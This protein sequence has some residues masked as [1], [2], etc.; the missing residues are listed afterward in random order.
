MNVCRV[1]LPGETDNAIKAVMFDVLYEFFDVSNCWLEW[2]SLTI[3]DS[4]Q[5][6]NLRDL[7]AVG[8]ND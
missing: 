4:G 5:Q 3:A 2:I 6:P 7:S 8:R 1:S